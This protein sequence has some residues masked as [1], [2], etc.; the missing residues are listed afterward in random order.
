MINQF[1]SKKVIAVLAVVGVILILVFQKGFN[2]PSLPAANNK[3]AD[4]SQSNE[5]KMLST[6]PTNLEGSTILPTQVISVTF[7]HPIENT[8]EFKHRFEPEVPHTLKLSEDKKTITIAGDPSF[9]VGVGYTLHISNDTK[10]DGGKRLRD[11][12]YVHF[13]T[14]SYRGI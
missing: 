3:P 6:D 12:Q 4:Q 10:F 13:R 14:I 2:A 9:Q 8:G 11:T 1:I 7:S 5:V